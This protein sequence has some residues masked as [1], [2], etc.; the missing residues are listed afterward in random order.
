MGARGAPSRPCDRPICYSTTVLSPSVLHNRTILRRGDQRVKPFALRVRKLLLLKQRDR[1]SVNT[2]SRLEPAQRGLEVTVP[3]R[4]DAVERPVNLSRSRRLGERRDY[5]LL[6]LDDLDDEALAVKIA[7]LVEGDASRSQN[8][9]R[10]SPLTGSGY[11]RDVLR[12]RPA[13]GA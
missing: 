10:V 5:V 12:R 1:P 9:V 6:A 7:V 3:R 13:F 8:I 2:K 4:P 11:G